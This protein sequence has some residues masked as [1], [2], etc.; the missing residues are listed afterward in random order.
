MKQVPVLQIYNNLR[1][2]YVHITLIAAG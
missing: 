1:K 2:E